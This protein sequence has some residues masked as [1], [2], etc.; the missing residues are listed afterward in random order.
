MTAPS[1][2]DILEFGTADASENTSAAKSAD[3]S[4]SDDNANGTDTP[5]TPADPN[6]VYPNVLRTY[7]STDFPKGEA[8]E[9]KAYTVKEFAGEITLRDLQTKGM[10]TENIHDPAKVY[11]ALRSAKSALPV[12]LV[13]PV[14]VETVTAPDG[15]TSEVETVSVDEHDASVFIPWAEAEKAWDERP[16]RGEGGVSAQK[17]SNDELL[18]DAAKKLEAY[19]SAVK[20]LA[21]LTKRT[22]TLKGQWEKYQKWTSD[23]NLTEDQVR[24]T[25]AKLVS[26][27]E[28][29]EETTP[30]DA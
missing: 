21:S 24:E 28:T 10:G 30:S 19:E 2:L 16:K 13:F 4:T 14:T 6:K 3:N 18:E 15:S 7:K 17:R 23:R 1:N 22:E 27:R 11:A 9:D 26:E 20:R 29:A 5:A 25:L 8:P 12:V